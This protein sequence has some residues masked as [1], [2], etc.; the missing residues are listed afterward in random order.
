VVDSKT[1]YRCQRS[2]TPFRSCSVMSSNSK[3]G[4]GIL[5]P[6]VP[7]QNVGVFSEMP[8]SFSV[9]SRLR[10]HGTIADG[11]KLGWTTT[12]RRGWE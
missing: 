1:R 2:G 3:P 6:Q 9:C 12:E 8:E 10:P 5:Q 11:S 7:R 4:L